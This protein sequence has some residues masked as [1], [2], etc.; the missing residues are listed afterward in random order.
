M[1]AVIIIDILRRAGAKVTVA[2][3]GSTKAVKCSRGVVL[4][5]D[6]LISDCS[7][8]FYNLIVLPGGQPGAR[9]LAECTELT[10]I[11]LRHYAENRPYA[12]ICAS[13]A[14]ILQPLG[15][16]RGRKATC[17][18]N[19]VNQ[20]EDQSAVDSRVVADGRCITSRGPGTAIDFSLTL[21]ELLFGPDKANEVAGPMVAGRRH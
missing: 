18:P 2:S 6:A 19:F 1:E 21:V 15:L 9:N 12:A 11:L 10:D 5:A 13:P 8:A 20:L 3:V 4:V 16:L 17:H 7:N 14:V